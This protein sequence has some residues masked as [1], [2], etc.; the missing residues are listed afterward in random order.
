MD[1]AFIHPAVL[2]YMIRLL[3]HQISR[4][5]VGN[6]LSGPHTSQRVTVPPDSHFAKDTRRLLLLFSEHATFK[7]LLAKTMTLIGF[8]GQ[9]VVP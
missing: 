2:N 7:L 1:H 6:C 4:C 5:N 8:L 9:E 3:M